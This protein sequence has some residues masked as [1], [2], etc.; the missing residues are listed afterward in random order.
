MD[1]LLKTG[2]RF[3]H[4]GKLP[5]TWPRTVTLHFP[6]GCGQVMGSTLVLNVQW[7][8]A[9]SGFGCSHTIWSIHLFLPLLRTVWIKIT[10]GFELLMYYNSF[11][12]ICVCSLKSISKSLLK[13]EICSLYSY[14]LQNIMGRYHSLNVPKWMYQL[15]L[16]RRTKL[17]SFLDERWLSWEVTD[18]VF[19]PLL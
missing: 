9:R 13:G 6:G 2:V 15:P 11:E 4:R 16:W 10:L 14:I 19:Q 5:P 8:Y 17:S 18:L 1:W 12:A 7:N 3:Y